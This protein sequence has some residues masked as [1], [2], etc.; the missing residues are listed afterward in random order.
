M[1]E[2]AFRIARKLSETSK[3][4]DAIAALIRDL[5]ENGE[6]WEVEEIVTKLGDH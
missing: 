2:T 6:S 3:R 4:A 1:R 5:A